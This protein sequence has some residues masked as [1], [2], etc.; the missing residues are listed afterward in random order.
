MRINEKFKKSGYFWLPS[1][2]QKKVPGTLVIKDG[3]NIELEV[4]ELFE[5]KNESLKKAFRHENDIKRIIGDIEEYGPIT[6]DECFLNKR[7]IDFRGIS[8]SGIYVSKALL[9]V[10]YEESENLLFNT[11]KFSVEGIDEWVGLSGIKVNYQSQYRTASITYSPP[12]EFLIKLSNGMKLLITFSYSFP[13]HPNFTEARITQKTY[14]KL[15]SEQKRPLDDFISIAY[16][17]NTLLCLAIDETVC[18]DQIIL[19]S[20]T[21]L[22]KRRSHPVPISFYYA[23][24]PYTKN[25]PKKIDYHKML[26]RYEQIQGREEYIF[27][28]WLA[29]YN[30]IE[31]SLNLY[32][33]EKTGG[34]KYL[35]G[36]FLALAQCLET[37]HRRTSEEKLMN[38]DVFKELTEN[39]I[40]QCAKEYREWLTGRLKHGNELTL[41]QRLKKIIEPFKEFFGQSRERNKLVKNIVDTRNY[42]THYDKS[43]EAEIIIDGNLWF[44]CLKMEALFQF[45]M[46]QI[47]GFSQEQVKSIFDKSRE[48]QL[49]LNSER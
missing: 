49:K 1:N 24:L 7:S 21:I 35:E 29:A 27:N 16:K 20:E 47:L 5:E 17:I 34:H 13:G 44:L 28:N 36:K 32:F 41:S 22:D 15:E 31:P 25:K 33:S 48:F 46:L 23:S 12:E 30:V 18:I 14:F 38:D 11:F 8:K 39:L 10:A 9:G 6:L 3:G 42:L 45:Q 43:L 19:K 4:L 2:P 40:N 26:F 37:Y